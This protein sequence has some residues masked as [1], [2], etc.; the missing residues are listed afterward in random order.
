MLVHFRLAT[1]LFDGVRDPGDPG[2]GAP[3]AALHEVVARKLNEGWWPTG[4]A[5]VIRYS[6]RGCEKR[7]AK[8]KL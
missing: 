6:K 7:P 4:E 5:P 1:I 3:Y 8:S 2:V